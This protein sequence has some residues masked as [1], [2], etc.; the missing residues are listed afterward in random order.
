M[1]SFFI[2]QIPSKL[3][4]Q[5]AP[6]ILTASTVSAKFSK[7][8]S[9]RAE[10]RTAKSDNPTKI[11]TGN[12]VRK[13]LLVADHTEVDAPHGSKRRFTK[14]EIARASPLLSLSRVFA[15]QAM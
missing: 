1:R 2:G 14:S 7:Q 11:G 8:T 6:S 15:R 9:R 13:L 3:F 4:F 5:N 10:I 12:R